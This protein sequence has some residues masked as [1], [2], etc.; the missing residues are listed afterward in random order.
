MTVSYVSQPIEVVFES[1][2]ANVTFIDFTDVTVDEQMSLEFNDHYA[3]E[4]TLRLDFAN[5]PFS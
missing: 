4:W 3:A 5:L 1:Y 2:F